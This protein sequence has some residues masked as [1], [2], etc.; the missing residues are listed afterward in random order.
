[1]KSNMKKFLGFSLVEI[2]VALIIVSLIVAALA[3]VITKRLSSSGITIGGGGTISVPTPDT[4]SSECGLGAYMPTGETVCRS[5]LSVTP[6]CEACADGEGVCTKCGNEY[7]LT[8]DN[9]CKKN[10]PCGDKAMEID[11]TGE[12]Y[13][14]TRFNIGNATTNP[15][16]IPYPTS[17]GIQMVKAGTTSEGASSCSGKCCWYGVTSASCDSSADYSACNRTVCNFDASS[18]ACDNLVLNGYDDWRLPTQNEFANMNIVDLTV[19]KGASGLQLCDEYSGYNSPQCSWRE[20]GCLGAD[21]N[22]CYPF[23]IHASEYP[24]KYRLEKGA[25]NQQNV[26]YPYAGSTRCIRKIKN[27]EGATICSPG[28]FLSG[29]S[30]IPCSNKTPNCKTCN[31][32]NGTCNV[33]AD[34][35]ILENKKCVWNS[36][37]DK[38]IKI[39]LSGV[40]YCITKYNLGNISTNSSE[41]PIP[42][43][44]VN[45]AKAGTTSEGASSCSG[46]CC[47]Y[48]VT[49]TS[50]DA[51]G[52]YNA[53]TRTLCNFDGASVA[54]DNLVLNGYD[55]WRLPTQNELS[56][57]NLPNLS[58]GLGSEGLQLCDEYSGYNSPQCSWRENGCLGADGNDCYPFFI[59]ASEYPKKYR[60]EKGA[61]NQQNVGYPYAGSVRCI[62]RVK[63][64]DSSSQCSVGT[65]EASE[66]LCEPCATKT[67][68]CKECNTKNGTCTLC[69]DG[70]ELNGDSCMVTGCGAKAIKVILG[71]EPYCITKYNVGYTTVNELEVPIPESAVTLVKAGTTSSGAISCSGK[72]C[73]YGITSNFCDQYDKGYGTCNRT[74]CNFDGASAACDNLVYNG[75]NDWR[76]PTQNELAS[77]NLPSI[78]IGLDT[79]GLQ[80]CDEYSGYNSPQCSWRENECLGADGNDCY[81]FFIHASEYPKKY[82][83]EKG[84]AN[85]QNVGYPYAGSTRCIRKMSA[86]EQMSSCSVGTYLNGA[87]CVACSTK[88]QNCKRCN[89]NT[90]ICTICNDGYELDGSGACAWTGCGTKAIKIRIDNEPY[91]LTKFNIGNTTFNPQEIPYP[92]NAGVTMT[93]AGTTDSGAT[94]CSGKCCWYGNTS[95]ACDASADYN[96]CTRTLCNYDAAA[97]LCDNLDY[98]GYTDWSLPTKNQLASMGLEALS[99]GL[100]SEGLQLCDEYSGYN[101][102]QCSWGENRCLGADGNDCYPFFIHAS[103]YPNKYRL[104]RGR[105]VQQNVGYPYSGSVRCIRKML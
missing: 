15:K 93:K 96:S 36:C 79:A 29:S 39:T 99:I 86:A 78:S 13:C 102:P 14:I 22:D 61:A 64:T 105:A 53:C 85:Q 30:C 55:D 47:W 101:S 37:G 8:A 71:G 98:Q 83:L 11:I 100:G 65:Y 42:S 44:V 59:H 95:V 7:I 26:G 23:F 54:C 52:E 31:N 10:D 17:A 103:V 2:L 97:A 5:C 62:R 72:C 90:G 51:S 70:Y 24:K 88:T 75:Y 60:L 94:S 45:L 63:S 6:N 80:L 104:E 3:P 4:P 18:T 92:T 81:P 76:L 91:C 34:G 41:I 40:D 67:S 38:A 82:R 20:N 57:M 58:V 12:K 50:C 49:S 16:E 1:M 35:Y 84:V 25:A 33:C 73:W 28:T 87:D 27:N 89:A 21:G 19:G 48:G 74:L 68:N 66:G 77:L 46:K 9:Q 43:G 56:N 69:A 32:S